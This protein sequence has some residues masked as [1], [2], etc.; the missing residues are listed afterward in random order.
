LDELSLS[1]HV[2]SRR[3]RERGGIKL[4]DVGCRLL[5]RE[6]DGTPADVN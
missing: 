2:K 1:E 3:R 6:K 5:M 4:Q